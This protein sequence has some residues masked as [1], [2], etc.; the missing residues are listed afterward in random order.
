MVWYC[1]NCEAEVDGS[2]PYCPS[3]GEERG[4]TWD[5]ESEDD[6]A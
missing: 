4:E 5:D 2:C 6:D 3:C 1:E